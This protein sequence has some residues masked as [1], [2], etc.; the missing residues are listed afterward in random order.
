MNGSRL[1]IVM[2]MIGVFGML[3]AY[4]ISSGDLPPSTSQEAAHSSI[5]RTVKIP[6]DFDVEAARAAL[7]EARRS[8]NMQLAAEL[9]FQIQTW[10]E[11]NTKRTYDNLERGYNANPGHDRR[12]ESHKP[13]GSQSPDWGTDVLISPNTDIYPVKIASLSNGDLYAFGVWF[14]GSAYHGYIRRSVDDGENWSTYWDNAFSTTT[15]IFS[16][17]ILVDNDTLVYWYI[18]DHPS[19]N[20]MRTWVK[21]CLPGTSDDPIYF[22]SPTGSFNPLDYRDLHLT[23]DAPVYGTA[24]YIYATWIESYGTGPDSTRV[25]NAVSFENNVGTWEIGPTVLRASSGANIYYRGTRIAFGSSTDMMWVVAYLHPVSYP[26]Y[27]ELIRGWY[28]DDYGSTWNATPVD[29]TPA[30]NSL[31]EFDPAVAGS[32]S[33]I[34]W[35][36]VATQT[37]TVAGADGALRNI[38]STDDGASWTETGLIGAYDNFFPDVWVD[39]NST[40][41]YITSRQ[42]RA[43]GEEY[44]RYMYKQIGD[45]T[46]GPASVGI[47]DD[48]GTELSGVY[49]SAVSYNESTGDAVIVWVS[50]EG[51]VYSIWFDSEGWTGIAGNT[52]DV[53]KGGFVNL[54]PNPMRTIGTISYTLKTE[55]RVIISLYDAA[56]RVVDNLVNETRPA[57]T[58]S[59]TIDSDDIAAGVYFVRV[60]TPDGIGTKTVTIVR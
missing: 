2:C 49:G 50:Y 11:L 45:P 36:C 59:T 37:D 60:E 28:S 25:M 14:D 33:N 29:I 57:G 15:R 4:D 43:I 24:E 17:G 32:H 13:V 30:T 20:E 22:G 55:G 47:N 7:R 6:N 26:T 52:G 3:S 8:G 40:A 51:S 16:P 21:V 58:Y 39:L 10:R 54:A 46:S 53:T 1:F 41:F 12:N 31:D 19:L 56:G 42:D 23:T 18:L 27:D 48:S 44:V 34:N 35:I 38:Y 5:S 9:A